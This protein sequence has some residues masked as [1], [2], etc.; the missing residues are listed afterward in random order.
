MGLCILCTMDSNEKQEYYN[1]TDQPWYRDRMGRDSLSKF[2]TWCETG[3]Y[4]ILTVC[5][6]RAEKDI[7]KQEKDVLKQKK[8]F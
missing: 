5:L 2:G 8:T 1:K 7:I 4:Q 3:R 6:D